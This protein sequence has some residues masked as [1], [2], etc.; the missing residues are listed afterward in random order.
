MVHA[1]VENVPLGETLLKRRNTDSFYFEPFKFLR[2]I[3]E[4][5]RRINRQEKQEQTAEI[6]KV[7]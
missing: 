3:R 4:I 5:E 2:T 6:S 1:D 7:N